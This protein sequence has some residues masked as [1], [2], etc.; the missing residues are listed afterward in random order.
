MLMTVHPAFSLHRRV[1]FRS[2]RF[3]GKPARS[4]RREHVGPAQCAEALPDVCPLYLAAKQMREMT[5]SQVN[6]YACDDQRRK[7]VQDKAGQRKH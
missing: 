4:Q 6:V 3:L 1:P 7:G 5:R 2:Y